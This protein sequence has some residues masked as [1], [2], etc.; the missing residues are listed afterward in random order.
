MRK[1]D[2]EGEKKEWMRKKGVRKEEGVIME[3]EGMKKEV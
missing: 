3:E 1:R 2:K